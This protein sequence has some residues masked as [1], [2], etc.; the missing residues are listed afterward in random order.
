MRIIEERWRIAGEKEE[1]GEEVGTVEEEERKTRREDGNGE[2][3]R[4]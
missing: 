2:E 4:Y 1:E 3:G